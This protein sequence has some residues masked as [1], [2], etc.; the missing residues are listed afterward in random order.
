MLEEQRDF[1]AAGEQW[2]KALPLLP[3]ESTQAAWI[4]NHI[5][6]LSAL[7]NPAVSAAVKPRQ[8]PKWLAPLVPILLFLSKGKALAALFN[9]KFLLSFGAFLGVYW[10]LFGMAF[11]LGFVVQILIHEMG[12]YIDI[13]RRGLPADMPLFL[14]GLG[15]FV[16]WNALGVSMETRAAVSLAGPL[17]G[18]LAAATCGVLWTMTDEPLWAALARTGAWL[19]LLNMIPVFGLDGGHAFL[20]LNRTQ[21]G[22]LLASA[23]LLFAFVGDGVLL[24]VA[25]GA[26]WRM[27]TKDI[28]EQPSVF[29]TSYYVAVL[30]ALAGVVWL[31][32]GHGLGPSADLGN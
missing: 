18:F 7:S 5:E 22:V 27:F 32:P 8:W 21:R 13:R 24:L 26:V 31:V 12:H 30:C 10:S 20:A 19:N 16:R 4:Q 25:L 11:A 6:R 15:A 28:P 29:A 3:V 9:A 17:A 1:K 14:P 2:M 23:L